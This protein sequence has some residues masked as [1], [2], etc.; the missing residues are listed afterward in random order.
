MKEAALAFS[1]ALAKVGD[2]FAMLAFSGQAAADT[3]VRTVKRFHEPGPNVQHRIGALEPD[4]LTR[5][6]G[7]LR[8]A[9]ASLAREPARARLLLVLSDGK[10][11]DEDGY[12]GRYGIEDVRPAVA[13]ARLQGASLRNHGR[14]GGPGIPP[15]PLR[16]PWL[17]RDLERRG[18]PGTAARDLSPAHRG[19]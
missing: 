13:E 12:D 10:P 16:R 17:H 4:A 2:R 19:R 3:R 1:E 11:Q 7:A 5:L 15:T 14:S 6:G 18:S 8:H 9:T